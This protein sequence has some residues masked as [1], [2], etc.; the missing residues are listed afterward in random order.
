MK[1]ITIR[2]Q[3]WAEHRRVSRVIAKAFAGAP[4]SDGTE[5]A[6]YERL[7]SCLETEASYVAVTRFRRIVGHVVF[8]EVKID[9][10]DCRWCGLGPLSV[11][12]RWQRRGIGS[13]LVEEGLAA[14]RRLRWEG[15]VVLGDPTFYGRFGFEH[16][17]DLVYPGPPAEYF[18]RIVFNGPAPKGV[19][20]Y[21]P[22][23][24]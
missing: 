2:G 21:N 23:F 11:L 24:G 12:P 6:I 9:G 16:D 7:F 18:Q 10:R 4:H 14:L 13:A 19:V 5:A 3:E 20:S 8:S 17:P 15:C 1:G 22:A